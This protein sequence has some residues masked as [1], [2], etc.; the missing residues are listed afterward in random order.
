ML[1]FGLS[2]KEALVGTLFFVCEVCGNQ[3][4]HQLVRRVRRFTLFFVPL[5]PVSTRYVDSCSACGR[6]IDVPRAQAE[7]AAGSQPTPRW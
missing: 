1:I 5:F 3:A 6:V 7:A 4:A 2:V